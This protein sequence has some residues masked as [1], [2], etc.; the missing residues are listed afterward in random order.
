MSALKSICERWSASAFREGDGCGASL[1]QQKKC[2][3]AG[4]DLVRLWAPE[5]LG[6]GWLTVAGPTERSAGDGE[7][8][9]ASTES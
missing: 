9:A 8:V 4:A 5:G 6:P 2:R 1:K 3:N 7:R